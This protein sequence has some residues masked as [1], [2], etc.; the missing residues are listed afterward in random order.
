M[1]REELKSAIMKE[2]EE[3]EAK[4]SLMVEDFDTNEVIF[5]YHEDY[6]VVSASMIKVPIML[7]ALEMVQE[8]KLSTDSMIELPAS[9]ILE[10]TEVFEYGA[11]KYT[12]E[13]LLVWMIINSDNTATN[14]LIDF[15]TMD[16]INDFCH[17][18]SGRRRVTGPRCKGIN[19][20]IDPP[21]TDLR[22]AT[23]PGD[24]CF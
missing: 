10:D 23:A 7:T 14:C 15:I 17:R 19:T 16:R 20:V 13:E 21:Q 24:P 2:I 11:R 12:I 6:P 3:A 4:I 22:A 9:T 8:R 1:N 5:T 18:L